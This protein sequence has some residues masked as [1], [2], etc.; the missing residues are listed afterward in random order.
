MHFE[1]NYLNWLMN[2]SHGNVS[3]AAGISGKERRALGK[4]LKKHNIDADQFRNR[5]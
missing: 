2:Q 3:Q 1:K 5:T 4:L